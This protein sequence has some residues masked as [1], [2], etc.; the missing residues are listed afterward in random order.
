MNMSDGS[1]GNSKV[2]EDFKRE[3]HSIKKKQEA[4]QKN[5]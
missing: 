1:I 4:F 3:I 2:L 5:V